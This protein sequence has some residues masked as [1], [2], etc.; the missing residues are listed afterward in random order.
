[1]TEGSGSEAALGDSGPWVRH[2]GLA[3]AAVTGAAAGDLVIGDEPTPSRP[4][5][6][7]LLLDGCSGWYAELH[8]LGAELHDQPG[9]RSWRVDVLCRPLGWLGNSYATWLVDDGVPP[10]TAQRVMGH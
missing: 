8:R 3:W 7:V 9:G 10:N 6:A 5:R 4:G 2:L 1:M